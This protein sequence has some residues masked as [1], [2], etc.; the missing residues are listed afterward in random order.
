M[1]DGALARDRADVLAHIEA[2]AIIDEWVDDA[3]EALGRMLPTM[4]LRTNLADDSRLDPL[5]AAIESR[6]RQQI[7][8][9]LAAL[10]A[11][12]GVKRIG[13]N[14]ADGPD[15]LVVF[16]RKR[17]DGIGGPL[18]P[19]QKVLLVSPGY[20]ITGPDGTDSVLLKAKVDEATPEDIRRASGR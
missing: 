10:A 7:L 3:P 15:Q 1:A 2:S 13:G 14:P 6:D 8:D 11:E 5:A 9:T 12:F 17:H 18:R 19:G 4:R 16:D 20:S